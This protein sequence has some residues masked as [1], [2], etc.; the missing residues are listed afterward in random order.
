MNPV[1]H[2]LGKTGKGQFADVYLVKEDGYTDLL[3]V[4]AMKKSTW[5]KLKGIKSQEELVDVRPV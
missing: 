3:V 1:K 2:V 4:K 5:K